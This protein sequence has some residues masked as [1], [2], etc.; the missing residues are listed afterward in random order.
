MKTLFSI[1][2]TL[3]ILTCSCEIMPRNT[4]KDC[5]AQCKGSTKSKAC[6]EFCDC[7]HKRGSL[8]INA[9]KNTTRLWRIVQEKIDHKKSFPIMESFLLRFNRFNYS[10]YSFILSKKPFS[11][12][13]GFGSKF[14]DARK[15]SRA[16]FSSALK[17]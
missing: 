4:L 9:W 8:L 7:I 6:L 13:F 16:F 5:R 2:I 14:L 10:K 11:L 3:L 1:S 15:S 12:R 17:C